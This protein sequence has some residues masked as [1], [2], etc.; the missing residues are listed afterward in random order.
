MNSH[1]LMNLWT[2]ICFSSFPVEFWLEFHSALNQE[3]SG[4]KFLSW[5]RN[6]GRLTSCHV[7][8][9]MSHHLPM[10]IIR[11]SVSQDLRMS[12]GELFFLL[13]NLFFFVL[14]FGV[15]DMF[16]LV[17]IFESS[18]LLLFALVPHLLVPHQHE[19]F[20]NWCVC[21]CTCTCW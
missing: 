17:L 6:A 18:D 10:K 21:P 19:R 5:P 14:S 16:T 4:C 9:T 20:V 1:P 2:V 7:C 12:V 15:V 13:F 3:I 11:C 8:F